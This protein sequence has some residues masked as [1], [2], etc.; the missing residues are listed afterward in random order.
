MED[1][2]SFFLKNHICPPIIRNLG[3]KEQ[4]PF[5]HHLDVICYSIQYL[6]C[7]LGCLI[8][9]RGRRSFQL[10]KKLRI[11]GYNLKISS[12]KLLCGMLNFFYTN[13]T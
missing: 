11:K 9:F 8:F 13:L 6:R 2:K 5:H 4:D 1:V 3:S 10:I 7:Q 12:A